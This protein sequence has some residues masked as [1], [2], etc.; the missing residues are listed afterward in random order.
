MPQTSYVCPPQRFE[1]RSSP[2]SP[3]CANIGI[4]S[5]NVL[6]LKFTLRTKFI[7]ESRRRLLI[8][9]QYRSRSERGARPLTDVRPSCEP[10]RPLRSHSADRIC[11]P[12]DFSGISHVDPRIDSFARAGCEEID[13]PRL[14]MNYS[15]SQTTPEPGQAASVAPVHSRRPSDTPIQFARFP[16]ESVGLIRFRRFS[17][18]NLSGWFPGGNFLRLHKLDPIYI[19]D[20]TADEEQAML[21]HGTLVWKQHRCRR[22]RDKF[23]RHSLRIDFGSRERNLGMQR[24]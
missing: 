13:S 14:S 2:D 15:A 5:E 11:G 19:S 18:V 21:L 16:P 3:R 20:L 22:R 12:T 10:E 9:L 4:V 24:K 6:R 7:A 1:T 8:F 17:R 23:R